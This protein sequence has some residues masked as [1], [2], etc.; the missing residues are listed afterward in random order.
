MTNPIVDPFVEV[1]DTN[2]SSDLVTVEATPSGAVLVT[3]NK[4]QRKNAFDAELIAAMGEAFETLGN[5]D[6][7][8]VVFLRGAGGMFSAGAD[9]DWMRAAADY[10]ERENR[11]DAYEMAKMLKALW[12]I[13]ALTVA[14]I[15]G[16]AFGGG[17]GVVSACDWAVATADA[18]FSFSEVRL[19]LIP[20]TIS[21]YV[22]GAIG[23]RHARALFATGKVFDAA[24]AEK[25]GLVSEVVA[26]AVELDAVQ[27]RIARDILACGPEAVADS[28]RLVDDM[29]FRPIDHVLMDESARRIA[30]ARVREEGQEGVRAFL[31]KRK[32]SWA[33]L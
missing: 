18:K 27:A 3:L 16:G 26:D 22:V 10:S 31:E 21:P 30:R 29:A 15:E 2:A 7:E 20:G 25:I 24:Y 33:A 12:D 19:G 17:A 32:P 11:D 14:L 5:A 13:P 1:P 8:R 23:K 4:P 28:K 9:L 6:G